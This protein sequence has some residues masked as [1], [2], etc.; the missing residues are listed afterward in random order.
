MAI[1][2]NTVSPL[3]KTGHTSKG[4][5]L[6]WT[7]N[8]IWY[9][10]DYMG[11]EGLLCSRNSAAH[12]AAAPDT[13]SQICLSDGQLIDIHCNHKSFAVY[14]FIIKWLLCF[15]ERPLYLPPLPI[16]S[17]RHR[18][19]PKNEPEKCT[20]MTSFRRYRAIANVC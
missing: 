1:N 5:Q 11:Y 16:S 18:I 20:I 8:R 2:L 3:H 13:N 14:Y 10:A 19:V 15:L 9:K 17:H 4:D 12:R 6:K 7:T